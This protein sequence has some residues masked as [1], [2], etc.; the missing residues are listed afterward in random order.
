MRVDTPYGPPSD[1]L[2][3]GEIRQADHL[4]PRH[5]RG[6]HLP[7]HHIN[8]RANLWALRSICGARQV[9]GPCAVGGLQPVR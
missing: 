5:G 9:L 2:F 8:Y 3:L 7:P 4:L 6:H 1:S